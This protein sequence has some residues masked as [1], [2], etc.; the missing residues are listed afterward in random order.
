MR[1]HQIKTFLLHL[2]YSW[3]STLNPMSISILNP[4]CTSTLLLHYSAIEWIHSSVVAQE[5]HSVK[6]NHALFC[7]Y[8]GTPSYLI[9][10]SNHISTVF[11]YRFIHDRCPVPHA[12]PTFIYSCTSHLQLL[13]LLN[14]QGKMLENYIYCWISCKI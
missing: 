4:N 5:F 13:L 7:S 1:H 12:N 11:T 6:Q 2:L 10:L 3:C 14:R 9:H 8:I